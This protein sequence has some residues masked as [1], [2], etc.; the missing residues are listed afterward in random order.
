MTQFTF[1]QRWLFI[2]GLIITV[3]GVTF[4]LANSTAL[5]GVFDIQVNPVFWDTVEITDRAAREF[6]SW[7]YGVLGATIAGWG[8][9][10]TFIAHYPFRNRERWAWN[11]LLVAV[12]IWFVVDTA[13]SMN[14]RVYFNVV[15]NTVLLTAT[16]LPLGFSRKHFA[17]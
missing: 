7:I 16:L 11:C 15:F 17:R 3:F 12:L 6:Q 4:A 5:F 1:W 10:I 13:I 9:F 14:F 8:V 2:V